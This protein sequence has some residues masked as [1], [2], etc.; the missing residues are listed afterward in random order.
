VIAAHTEKVRLD[1]VDD[2]GII[3][4]LDTPEDYERMKGRFA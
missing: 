4:D 1:K 2:E 3:L